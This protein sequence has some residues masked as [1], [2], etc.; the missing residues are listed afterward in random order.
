MSSLARC[1]RALRS[2]TSSPRSRGSQPALEAGGRPSIRMRCWAVSRAVGYDRPISTPGSH[3]TFFR[4]HDLTSS[5]RFLW[6]LP[7]FLRQP[8]RAHEAR[9]ALAQ[10]LE[11]RHN[12][13]LELIREVVYTNSASPYLQLLRLAGCEYGDLAALVGREGLTGALETLYR[14][15]VYLTIDE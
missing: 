2:P 7:G 6:R 12:A 9:A 15:G 3:V 5:A 8:V 13:L 11:R 4:P 14:L 10:R 1:R